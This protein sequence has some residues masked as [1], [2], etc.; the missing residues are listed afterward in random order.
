[1][2]VQDNI[3][4]SSRNV[5]RGLHLQEPHGQG[6]LVQVLD[7]DVFDVAVDVR[8][9]SPTFGQWV[10]ERLTGTSH[11]QLFI[12][13]GFAHGFCVLSDTAIF[14][15]KCTDVY[16]P[17]AEFSIAWNDPT[18]AITWPITNPVLS[19]KDAEAKRLSEIPVDR[20]PHYRS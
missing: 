10:S 3:S 16:D 12:P 20:L 19:A 17:A 18:L 11:R 2:F 1:V 6:R 8:V 5:L 7:G 15:Y 14:S 9:G 4:K 13:K